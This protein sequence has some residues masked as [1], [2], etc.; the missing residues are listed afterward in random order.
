MFQGIKEFIS[1]YKE[2]FNREIKAKRVARERLRTKGV[3]RPTKSQLEDEI[4]EVLDEWDLKADWGINAHKKLQEEGLIKYP[5][6]IIEEYSKDRVSKDT[7]PKEALKINLLKKNQRYYEKFIY[8]PINE[9]IGYV[10]EVFVDK[11]GYINIVE[12]KTT[13]N[14]NKNYTFLTPKGPIIN[15]YFKPIDNII[16]CN[17]SQASLQSSMYMYLLWYYNKKLKSGTI[18]IK[19]I[20][21]NEDTE[22][23]ETIIDHNSPYLIE[24]VK[25]LLQ[26][27][28]K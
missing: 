10:D 5:N 23:I 25:K 13:N 2:P 12:Y 18:T 14:L 9:L 26:H 27:K 24:E 3:D 21:L 19:H 11:K 7:I 8:D 28:K 20:K 1:V 22:N 17:F 6:A 4:E 15:K 16:D